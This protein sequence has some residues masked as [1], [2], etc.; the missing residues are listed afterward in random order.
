KIKEISPLTCTLVEI[1]LDKQHPSSAGTHLDIQGDRI[2]N[3][4]VV[5]V[6]DAL[7]TGRTMVYAVSAFIREGSSVIRTAVLADR[8]HKKFPIAADFVGISMAT[9]LQEHLSFEIEENQLA[10]YLQ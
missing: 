2:K 8:N 6:D 7:N 9:T 3:H 10:L 1:Q 5:I 4:P